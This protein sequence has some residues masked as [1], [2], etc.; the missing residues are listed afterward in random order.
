MDNI[1]LKNS[2]KI[3][4]S[5]HLNPQW[6]EA[7]L[8][9]FQDHSWLSSSIPDL[10]LHILSLFLLSKPS[11]HFSIILL[12][13]SS[14]Q[15]TTSLVFIAT[16]DPSNIFRSEHWPQTDCPVQDHLLGTWWKERPNK[17]RACE[18]SCYPNLLM[19]FGRGNFL[20]LLFY[21]WTALQWKQWSSY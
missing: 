1:F 3:K 8:L 14:H 10:L 2:K 20:S 21:S 11:K 17:K 18:E 9:H 4:L 6:S 16:P 7:L 13:L 5:H 19:V 12:H 15:L